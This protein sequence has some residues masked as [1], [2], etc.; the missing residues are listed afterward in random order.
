[1]NGDPATIPAPPAWRPDLP[2]ICWGSDA[3]VTFYLSSDTV[4]AWKQQRGAAAPAAA[5]AAALT[6]R[7][8]LARMTAGHPAALSTVLSDVPLSQALSDVQGGGVI[9][10]AQSEQR[11]RLRRSR[12]KAH[13]F[14]AA[15]A[16]CFC[17]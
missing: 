2:I 14:A 10:V 8:Q 11:A 12:A 15:D 5:A 3:R 7:V 4:E 1:M 9:A 16:H 13:H 6:F 17:C